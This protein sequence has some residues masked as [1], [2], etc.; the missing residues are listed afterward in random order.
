MFDRKSEDSIMRDSKYLIAV[1][2]APAIEVSKP[3][4]VLVETPVSYIVA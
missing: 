2:G 1:F 3:V 4:P